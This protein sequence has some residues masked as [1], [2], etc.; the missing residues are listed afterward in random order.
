MKKAELQEKLDELGIE[1]DPKAKNAVLQALLDEAEGK[2]PVKTRI[3]ENSDISISVSIKTPDGSK[4]DEEITLK[5]ASGCIQLA[6]LNNPH[7]IFENLRQGLSAKYGV[8]H[9]V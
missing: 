8:Q 4:H 9:V 6:Y 1:Y 2:P 5:N 7:R 3:P